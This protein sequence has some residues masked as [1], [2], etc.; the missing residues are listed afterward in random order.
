MLDIEL[1]IV[2]LEE[3]MKWTADYTDEAEGADNVRVI[4]PNPGN[5]RLIL[6]ATVA[7]AATRIT[8]LLLGGGRRRR[9]RCL[10]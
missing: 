2:A 7:A 5:P 6:S 4:R 10:L 3:G 9:C 1:N 8:L